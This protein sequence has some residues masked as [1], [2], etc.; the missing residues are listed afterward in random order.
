LL[1]FVPQPNLLA[2][3]FVLSAQPNKMAECRNLIEH[4]NHRLNDRMPP[5]RGTKFA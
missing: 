2:G 4:S 1:G 3:N 5:Y